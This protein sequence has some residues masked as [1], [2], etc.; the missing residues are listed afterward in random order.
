MPEGSLSHTE[1]SIDSFLPKKRTIMASKR[2][3]ERGAFSRSG[4][5]LLYPLPICV[6]ASHFH[7]RRMV[8]SQLSS[9]TRE[10]VSMARLRSRCFL[11]RSGDWPPLPGPGNGLHAGF[12]TGHQIKVNNGSIACMGASFPILAPMPGPGVNEAPSS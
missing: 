4:N 10:C 6:K 11:S 7:R 12:L 2:S 3:S 8:P 5:C 9:L 1:L